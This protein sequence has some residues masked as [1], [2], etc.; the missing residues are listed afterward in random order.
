MIRQ[1]TRRDLYVPKMNPE[2]IFRFGKNREC[3]TKFPEKDKNKREW[4]IW[5]TMV[6]MLTT[7]D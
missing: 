4:N 5:R 7:V 3:N 2:V 1:T 6:P